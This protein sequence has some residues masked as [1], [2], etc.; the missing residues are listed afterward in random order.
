MKFCNIIYYN[1]TDLLLLLLLLLFILLLLR[2]HSFSTYAQKEGEG[3]NRCACAVRTRGG[4]S[5]SLR[6]YCDC[7]E[8]NAEIDHLIQVNLCVRIRL[9]FRPGEFAYAY[10]RGENV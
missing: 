4:R 2:D 5:R 1:L 8:S 9:G 3:L 6:T 10:R 7:V